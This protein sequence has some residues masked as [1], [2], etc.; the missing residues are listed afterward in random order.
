MKLQRFAFSAMASPCELHLLGEP[1]QCRAAAKA[2][3]AEVRRI[4]QKYSRY[5]HDSVLSQINQHAGKPTAIDAETYYLLHYAQVCWQQSD[6]LFDISSG[7]LRQCWDFKHATLPEPSE[8]SRCL[9]RIGF[10]QAQLSET[11]LQLP[12]SME[13][14][15]GGLG[16]EY[17]ADR[18]AALCR[19]HG[20]HHGIIDLG[21][22]LLVLGPKP[23]GS[24]WLLGVRNPRAPEQAFAQLPV[25]EGGMATSGD[26]ERFFILDDQRYCHLL[27]PTSGYPVNFWASVTVLAPS[28]MLAGSFSTIAML[29]QQPALEWL[30]QQGLH[31]LAIRPDGQHFSANGH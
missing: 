21:G 23:D 5:R 24:P 6:G 31:Y 30:Q 26:Y 19:Q 9:T 11:S 8:L 14:D 1:Q 28:C 27:N 4:E 20:I 17:A 3:E 15:L 13:I 2:A 7:V 10:N 22:D 16:K 25:Y 29:K 12:A 18:A